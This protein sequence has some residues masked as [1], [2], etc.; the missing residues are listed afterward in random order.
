MEN[1]LIGIYRV[2]YSVCVKMIQV[3]CVKMH[4]L[5]Q[6][7]LKLRINKIDRVE[8][9]QKNFKQRFFCLYMHSQLLIL[10]S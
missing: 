2:V 9:S 5:G 7:G 6:I 1:I 3:N 8:K 10:H 4:K